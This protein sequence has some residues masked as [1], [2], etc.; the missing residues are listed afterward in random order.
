MSL[1]GIAE[2]QSIPME[3]FSR[4]V[5]RAGK[6]V[7]CSDLDE[8]DAGCLLNL[9]GQMIIACPKGYA[10]GAPRLTGASHAWK[11]MEWGH[12][13]VAGSPSRDWLYGASVGEQSL[14]AVGYGSRKGCLGK[15]GI[16]NE[17]QLSNQDAGVTRNKNVFRWFV[18]NRTVIHYYLIALFEP[19][20]VKRSACSVTAST[21]GTRLAGVQ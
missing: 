9:L 5:V 20:P 16:R 17:P 10:S 8:R 1:T 2:T 21:P 12:S 6:V 4:N 14:R 13:L 19:D 18:F 15:L 3:G 11:I 7:R